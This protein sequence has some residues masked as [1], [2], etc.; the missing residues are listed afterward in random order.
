MNLVS[1]NG[2]QC[3]W[4]PWRK[5]VHIY[6]DWLFTS[7]NVLKETYQDEH[8]LLLSSLLISELSDTLQSVGFSIKHRMYIQTSQLY[9]PSRTG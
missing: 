7:L 9:M 8:L 6:R 1:N 2:E 4:I 3:L 5:K